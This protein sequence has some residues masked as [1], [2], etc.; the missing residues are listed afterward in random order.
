MIARVKE[1]NLEVTVR[2]FFFALLNSCEV[3]LPLLINSVLYRT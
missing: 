2:G 3:N 1:S